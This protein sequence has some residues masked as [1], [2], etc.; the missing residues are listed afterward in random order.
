MGNTEQFFA[1]RHWSPR[2]IRSNFTKGGNLRFEFGFEVSGG[3][4]LW[5][6]S[7]SLLTQST[8][9]EV[10]WLWQDGAPSPRKILSYGDQHV[11]VHETP[12]RGAPG[13]RLSDSMLS[14]IEL[15][16]IHYGQEFLEPLLDWASGIN[17]LEL[18]NPNAMRQ[19]DRGSPTNIG[20]RGERLSGFLAGLSATQK[21]NLVERLAPYYPLKDVSTTRKRAGW[22]DMRIAETYDMG[23]VATSH[24]SDGFLRLLA[25]SAIPEFPSKTGA[26]LLDEVEDGIEPHILPN[27]IKRVCADAHVQMIM[28]SH[29]PLL[30][31][32][33]DPSEVTL[34]SR[35]TEGMT[36]TTPLSSLDTV[37]AGLDYFGG[38]EIWAMMDAKTVRKEAL[39][40]VE[41]APENTVTDHEG[42][43]TVAKTLN[44]AR[45]GK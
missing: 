39:A 18:L 20:I 43:L 6:F 25:L 4:I 12:Q 31:N 23:P 28:T 5:Q 33:F 21:S 37:K 19:G 38:G 45:T 42:L 9:R 13:L 14:L 29:S 7:W 11:V 8:Q 34:V 26:V 10:F 2:Q 30:V 15:K 36:V 40:S 16:S 1:D 27:I 32:F 44:F 22:V 35:T 24:I 17:S 41:A 3:R